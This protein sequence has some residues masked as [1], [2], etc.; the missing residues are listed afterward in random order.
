LAPWRKLLCHPSPCMTSRPRRSR[1]YASV[2][3]H[4]FFSCR[5]QPCG[6][7]D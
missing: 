1:S 5:W 2:H 7:S 3:V 6:P 4:R